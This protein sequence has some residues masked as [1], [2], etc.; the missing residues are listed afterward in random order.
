[1]DDVMTTGSTL[2]EI[3]KTL[4][5]AGAAHVSNWVLAR[6]LPAAMMPAKA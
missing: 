1:V 2:N 5:K 6:T 3:A 4:K